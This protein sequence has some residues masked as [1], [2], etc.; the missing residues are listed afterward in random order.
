[1]RDHVAL[2]GNEAPIP[3]PEELPADIDPAFDEDAYLRAFPDVALALGR[4]QLRSAYEHYV[5]A[6]KAERRL[7]RVAYQ[8]QIGAA[9]PATVAEPPAAP[10]AEAAAAPTAMPQARIE[11][12]LVSEGG[13]VFLVGWADDRHNPL[14]AVTLRQGDIA[15]QSWT[16]FARLRRSDVEAALQSNG[17]HQHGFWVFAGPEE[18]WRAH[19]LARGG[20]CG[21]EL[22]YRSGDISELRQPPTIVSD[23]ELRDTVMRYFAACEYWG[24]RWVEAFASLDSGVGDAF[25]A[26][27]RAISERI[28]ALAVSERFGQPARKPKVSVVVP[29]YGIPDYLFLQSCAYAQSRDIGGYE[30]IYV[31]NSPELIEHLHREARIGQMIYGLPQTLVCLPDNAG[32]GAANNV[33]ARF[34]RSDRLLCLNPDVFPRDPEWARRH[35]DLLASLPA[36]QTRLFGA[37]LYYDDGSLMHGGMYFDSD[38]GFRIGDAGI[39]TRAM[40]RVEHYGKG[41]PQW[42][43]QYVASRPVPAVTGAFMSIDRGW[44]ETLGGFTQDYVFGHYEDADLC[45]KSLHAGTPAWF[46][47]IRMWHLEGKGSRRLPQHEGGS[48]VNRWQFTRTWQQFV[49]SDLLGPTP[50][51]ALLNPAPEPVSAEA[52]FTARSRGGA[53]RT[54]RR[55]R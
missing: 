2:S 55:A 14:V 4:G 54:G 28:T 37:A 31:V 45:L 53:K 19:R 32:F 42:A 35:L 1:M 38:S 13:A 17:R 18:N 20:E 6:G 10:P 7:E 9:P 52:Q 33:A 46:H 25:V 34:A 48:L 3:P 44:F 36:D 24:N 26:F 40:L 29:I 41:A 47:D 30:F 5:I 51:H 49:A 39:T 22:C 15:R 21:I 23:A 43:R 50:A 16:S 11:V 8:R 27:N 12:L